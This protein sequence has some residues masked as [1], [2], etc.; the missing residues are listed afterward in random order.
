MSGKRWSL[1][2]SIAWGEKVG[3][4]V[5]C[6]F[7]PS[8]AGNQLEM[9]QPETFDAETIDREL[10]WAAGLGMN[11]VRV[12]LH[13]LLYASDSIG[14]LNRIDQ[15]LEIADSHKIGMIP[16]LFDGVFGTLILNS[17][18]NLNRH[19]NYITQFGYKARGP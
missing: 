4:L 8:T 5:G 18:L 1:E 11:A 10:G 6:N 16:V 19:Q 12:Y 15:V 9:W 13:D 7:T 3:W 14:F 17:A 2:Q